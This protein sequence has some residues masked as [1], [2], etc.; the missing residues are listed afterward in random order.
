M[1]DEAKAL[2]EIY[3]EAM[4]LG[5][6]N[7]EIDMEPED[8]WVNEQGPNYIRGEALHDFARRIIKP[9]LAA[10]GVNPFDR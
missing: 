10:I 4:N 2:V 7:K 6:T 3:W 8:G 9:A 1:T 5:R